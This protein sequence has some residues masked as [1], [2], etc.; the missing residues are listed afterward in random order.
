MQFLIDAV[1]IRNK[2]I[3]FH[4]FLLQIQLN[5][6]FLILVIILFININLKLVIRLQIYILKSCFLKKQSL[7]LLLRLLKIFS[8]NICKIDLIYEVAIKL[9]LTLLLYYHV[10]KTTLMLRMKIPLLFGFHLWQLVSK[11]S[12]CKL[13]L[14]GINISLIKDFLN[15]LFTHYFIIEIGCDWDFLNVIVFPIFLLRTLW[16]RMLS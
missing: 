7:W 6:N 10:W 11:L 12:V 1:L 14:I 4:L 16:L 5:F 9:L 15:N 2:L 3:I 8:W 13:G